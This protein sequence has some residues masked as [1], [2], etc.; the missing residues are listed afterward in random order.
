MNETPAVRPAFLL[1]TRPSC[2][3]VRPG[4]S[5]YQRALGAGAGSPRGQPQKAA[6]QA[7]DDKGEIADRMADPKIKSNAMANSLRYVVAATQSRRRGSCR[8]PNARRF[9]G[10]QRL[11]HDRRGV[12]TY[13]DTQ[14]G[15]SATPWDAC[16]WR[17]C[18]QWR[19]FSLRFAWSGRSVNRPVAL[20]H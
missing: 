8:G 4:A 7:I 17:H 14:R 2:G 15:W 16:G 19:G 20:V 10:L 13:G 1:P 12:S 6:D 5:L 11:L 18:R 9:A 3:E